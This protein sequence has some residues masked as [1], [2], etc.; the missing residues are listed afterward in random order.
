MR[1]TLP[2][3]LLMSAN[4]CADFN[5]N[6]CVGSGTFEQHIDAYNNDYEKI[7]DVGDI[8]KGIQGLHIELIS[9][10]DVDIRLY[11]E[12]NDKIVHWPHGILN[13]SYLT[14]KPYK[15]VDV[16]YSGYN[17]THGKQGHE[18]I[19]ITGKT[20]TA[21]TMKAFGY[22]SGYATI[23]YSWTGKEGCTP[24]SNGSG[25]FIQDIQQETTSLVGTIPPNMKDLEI[26][27]SS[28]KD[29]DIQLY[30][31][32]GT[33]IVSWKPAG[34]LNGPNKQSI[35]YH[36]MKIEWSGYNGVNNKKGHEY[37][38]ISGKTSEMLVMKVYGYETGKA[39][40]HY[41][42]GKKVVTKFLPLVIIRVEFNDYK[43][44]N[45]STTWNQKIFG[46]SLSQLNH[47]YN[48]ISHQTFQF[49]AAKESDGIV[50]DGIITVTL[51]ENHPNTQGAA[52][53]FVSR[54]NQAIALANPYIDFSQYDTNHNHAI[55][56]DELQ[57]MFLIAGGEA[58]LG[59]SPSVWAHQWCM[60]GFNAA[61]PTHDDVKLM[62]CQDHGGYS[63]F[64]ERH[65]YGDATIGVI[66]HELGHAVFLLPDLYDSDYS[67]EG[68]GN[69][70]L[71]SAGAWA[72]KAGDTGPGQTPIHMTGWSKIRAG[73]IKATPIKKSI[74]QLHIDASNLSSYKV[75]KLNT[76]K[77]GE[78]FLLENRGLHGYDKGLRILKG[79]KDFVGGLSI[80]HIDDNIKDNSDEAHK[81]VDVEE[82]NNPGLDKKKH[83][84]DVLNLFYKGNASSFN[85]TST[86]NSKKYNG[87]NS[88]IS[89]ENISHGAAKMTADITIQ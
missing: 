26:K 27:L 79:G 75:Y 69:F 52:E 38:K 2:I 65:H 57:I 51:N 66:A 85:A 32:D 53:K 13:K 83:R 8:P 23:N 68:I 1:K 46:T 54:L 14:T 36:G 49:A 67:S 18:Y 70:G 63:L 50:N 16:S 41:S 28:E 35:V 56:I 60:Y 48:E 39:N 9:E 78:Y 31:R 25:T 73:F 6:E 42:W 20:P 80:M 59:M 86:P 37:I 11:G 4:L 10:K 76:N 15:G 61:A 82:A 21:M 29:I 55:S 58:S 19:D 3:L 22:R 47:Y 71:M 17:G 89:V 64:G 84:G 87:Q 33:A 44:M 7:V 43:F 30:G 72:S 34:L 88:G 40:V 62:N 74:S 77:V 81:W 12:N 45:D 24:N 5:F